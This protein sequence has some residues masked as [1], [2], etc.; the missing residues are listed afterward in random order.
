MPANNTTSPAPTQTK[1]PGFE[2]IVAALSLI[3][4]AGLL[5]YVNRK[6]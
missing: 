5:L 1:S 4:V 6:K 2:A 3:A